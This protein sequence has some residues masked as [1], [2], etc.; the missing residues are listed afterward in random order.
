MRSPALGSVILAGP[1]QPRMLYDSL[2]AFECTT[3][4]TCNTRSLLISA[5][6][7]FGLFQTQTSLPLGSVVL[8]SDEKQL[9]VHSLLGEL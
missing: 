5:A 6:E 3:A 7:I 1:F 2:P 9:P 4:G 8:Q